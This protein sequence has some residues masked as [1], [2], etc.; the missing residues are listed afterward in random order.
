MSDILKVVYDNL[1]QIL[2]T[3]ITGIAGYLGVRIKNLYQEYVTDKLKKEIVERTV[4]YVEQIGKDLS[5]VDKKS[6]AMEKATEWLNEKKINV[7]NTE[8][9]IL[10]ESAV[11][12]L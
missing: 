11:K 10:I 8:L 12:C 4:N 6:K 5:C 7:S 1:I 9:E 2:F 3:I